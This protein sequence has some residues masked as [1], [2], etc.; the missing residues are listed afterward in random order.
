MAATPQSMLKVVSTGLQDLERLNA[1]RGNPITSR[2]RYVLKRRTRWAAQWIRVDFDNLANFGTTATVTLPILG[3]LISRAVLVVSLPDIYTPQQN[4]QPAAVQPSWSWTNNLGKAICSQAQFLING[5]VVD[6]IDSRLNEVLDEFH[7]PTEHFYSTNIMNYRSVIGYSDLAYEFPVFSPTPTL[8]AVINQ[9]LDIVFPFWWNRGIGPQVLPIQALYKDT[10]QISCQ[11]RPIQDCVYTDSRKS[12]KLP[13]QPGSE[14]PTFAG[15][16]FLDT[17]GNRIPGKT[18]PT[19]WSFADAYWLIEYISL[20][21]RE[22]GAFRQADLQI[23]F[24]QH[25]ALPVTRT[26]GESNVR[27]KLKESGLVRDLIWVGQNAAAPTYNNYFLFSRDLGLA[28]SLLGGG[29]ETMWWPDARIHNYNYGDGYGRPAFVD[30]QSDPFDAASLWYR[31]QRRFDH[32]GPSFFRSLIPALNCKRCPLVDRYIYRY[33]FGFWP[34]GGIAETLG[35][36]ADEVRGAANWDKIPMRELALSINSGSCPSYTWDPVGVS[37]EI[38]TGNCVAVSSLIPATSD[39]FSI[40]LVGG[41]PQQCPQWRYIGGGVTVLMQDDTVIMS[42]VGEP[43][44]GFGAYIEGVVDYQAIRRISGFQELYI[45]TVPNGSASLV[46]QINDGSGIRYLWIAVAGGGG[47]GWVEIKNN[48]TTRYRGGNAGSAVECG[49]RGGKDLRGTA[50]HSDISGGSY[51]GGGGGREATP[52]LPAVGQTDGLQILTNSPTFVFGLTTA[53]GTT[54]T[55]RGGDGYWGGGSGTLAGGGG[56]SYV[57]QYITQVTTGKSKEFIKIGNRYQ[58]VDAKA[59][60]RRLNR[61]RVPPTN[62]DIYVWLTRINIMRITSG[63]AA[64]LFT[65]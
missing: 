49:T 50:G 60:I 13:G 35:Y 21:D 61:T 39:G 48:I 22:A 20:E 28:P 62:L 11:F 12:A 41:H 42:S 14:L 59:T 45:R 65:E 9:E 29:R 56:G 37:G 44:N 55:Y 32:E 38:T 8:N 24:E 19:S 52:I 27:I 15:C 26:K 36:A 33:D 63:R 53:G 64:I 2:Y 6:Q 25:I 34:S 18:M 30:R 46:A 3:E 31:G 5:S 58:F 10:I 1:S 23:P 47:Q 16:P 51:G 57:S 54:R 7:T 4:A 17:S 40:R 43:I